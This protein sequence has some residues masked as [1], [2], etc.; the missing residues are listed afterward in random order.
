MTTVIEKETISGARRSE[1]L[2]DARESEGPMST[3]FD[4]EAWALD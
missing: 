3:A 1:P 4:H 2:G